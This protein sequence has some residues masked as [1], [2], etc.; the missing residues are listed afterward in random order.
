MNSVFDMR[1]NC[2]RIK[3]DIKG[4]GIKFRGSGV[5]YPLSTDVG[6]DYVLTAQHILKAA[7][8]ENL[9]S[10]LGKLSS[11]VIEVF[12]DKG[13]TAYNSIAKEDIGSSLLPIGDDFLIIRNNKGEKQFNPFH[14]ADDLIEEK[15]MHLYGISGMAQDVITR[16]DCKC[17]DMIQH[18]SLPKIKECCGNMRLRMES[19]ITSI[20]H[21]H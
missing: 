14:L 9:S 8:N 7:N 10:Q 12:E 16:L 19:F 6:Y 13:F 15:S 18:I 21:K 1:R 17:V 20:F 11:I 2:V 4:T 5:L 3:A